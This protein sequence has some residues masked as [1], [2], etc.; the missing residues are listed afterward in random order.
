MK[1]FVFLYLLIG[2]IGPVNAQAQ[3]IAS[4]G[5]PNGNSYYAFVGPVPKDKA[6]WQKDGIKDGSFNL[7][8]LSTGKFDMFYQDLFKNI[9]SVTADGATVVLLRSEP[10]NIVVLVTYSGASE[11]YTFWK[12]TDG[13]LQYSFMQTKSAPIGLLKMALLVGDCRYINFNLL[14]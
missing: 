12:T 7:T 14:R 10:N 1:I 2:L 3:D 5:E 4:C 11:F 9:G 13:K 8:K 6:G